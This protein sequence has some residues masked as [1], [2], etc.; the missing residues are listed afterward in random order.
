MKKITAVLLCFVL[1]FG[2]VACQ[3]TL[4]LPVS[5]DYLDSS[6]SIDERLDNLLSQMTLDEKAGQMAQGD[7]ANVSVQDMKNLGLGSIL[8]GGGSIPNNDNTV[9]SWTQAVKNYQE[10]ALSRRLKIPFIYGIDAVHGHNTV[11]NAVIFPHNIGIGAANDIELTKQMGAYV[12]QELKLTKT[13][14]NFG[15]CVA[16]AQ[17]LRWGRTYESYSSDPEIVTD[18]AL[19]FMEG[20]Q[21]E[22]ILVT[23]KHYAGDGGTEFGTGRNK[24][25]DR[26]DVTI[27]MDEFNKIHL[28]PYKELVD[29]GVKCIMVSF[30]SYK[31]VKMHQHKE[32]ITDVLKGEFGFKGFVISDWEGVLEIN[33]ATYDLK[34]AAAI[35]A[36]VD[37]LMEPNSF[38]DAINAIKRGVKAG[39]I[40]E[41]R[42]DDAV[43]R[44]L[45]VKFEMGLFDDPYLE[46]LDID[47]DELGDASGRALAKQLVEK[48]QVLLKNENDILPFKNG[49]KIYVTGPAADD[50][51]VQCGGWT[52]NWEGFRGDSFTKGTSILKGLKDIASKNNIEIITDQ[53]QAD[54]ADA[55]LLVI[56]EQPYAEFKGDTVDPS[57]TGNKALTDNENAINRAKSVNKP[58]A[59]VIVAGRNVLIGDYIDEWDAVVMVYLPGTEGDGVASVLVGEVG[60]SGKLPM[61]WYKTV[62]DIKK[63]NPDLL[64]D[65]GHGLTTEAK[66]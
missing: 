37:M 61:P 32:L 25:I 41:A 6:L 17:D 53:K 26:G 40:S 19:A 42:L 59:T 66:A 47:I 54:Q 22:G 55:V 49:Q 4:R 16:V 3:F 18:L 33:E 7:Q 23:A 51:G 36:G 64:F 2:L 9:A 1:F 15:P 31:G 35:N 27:D 58:I 10:A 13:I 21:S 45:R 38:K 29:N 60:F 28:N 57:I 39:R 24:L 43:S 62:N 11:T 8:S 44:I 5:E 20:Q 12:A 52:I 46:N 14:F 30:S 65:I 56:G 50:I 48:S 63:P 34:V